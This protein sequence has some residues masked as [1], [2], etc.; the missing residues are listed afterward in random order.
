MLQR[1]GGFVARRAL[2]V[3]LTGIVVAIAAAAY[4][5]GVF[6]SL[7]NG[8][9]DDPD[10]EATIEREAEQDAFGN[11]SVDVAA[12]YSDAEHTADSPEFQAA[13][14]AVVADPP[15]T[16]SPPLFPTTKSRPSKA[17]SAPTATPHRS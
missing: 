4:G 13:V 14:E 16:R 8:G 2:T 17:W 7:S 11:R 12:I 5:F 9:F 1:W 10:S 3:L 15:A 6:D